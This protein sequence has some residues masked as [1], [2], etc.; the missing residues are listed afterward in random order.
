M[1]TIKDFLCLLLVVVCYGVAGR[2]DYD[3]ALMLEEAQRHQASAINA[4]CLAAA[5]AT[6]EQRRPASIEPDGSQT[7]ADPSVIE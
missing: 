7:D 5:E 6:S 4:D 3:D 2:M 1:S